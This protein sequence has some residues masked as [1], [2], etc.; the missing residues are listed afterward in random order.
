MF[1]QIGGLCNLIVGIAA[2]VSNSFLN[3][4]S[5]NGKFDFWYQ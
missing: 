1:L 2:A 4:G 5:R 3:T